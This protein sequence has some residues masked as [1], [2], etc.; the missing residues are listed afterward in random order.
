MKVEICKLDSNRNLA[1][2]ELKW[3]VQ[4]IDS[5]SKNVNKEEAELHAH[6]KSNAFSYYAL[7]A[8]GDK[9]NTFFTF[10]KE[11][12]YTENQQTK[13][14]SNP[15]ALACL[16][17]KDGLL[18][19]QDGKF[20][21]SEIAKEYLLNER[22]S[23]KEFAFI[24]LSKQWIRVDGSCKISLLV[25]LYDLIKEDVDFLDKLYKKEDEVR[26]II[27]EK[28]TGK[29]LEPT[30]KIDF[31]RFDILRNMMETA[32][33]ISHE[34]DKPI[35]HADAQEILEAFHKDSDKLSKY[36]DTDNSFY[37]YI[38]ANNY[39]VLE[40]ISS[41]NAETFAKLYPNL[42]KVVTG[43]NYAC[44]NKLQVIY[45]GSPGTG[46]SYS[47]KDNLRNVGIIEDPNE[48]L[49]E[50]R[51]GCDR[52]FRTTFHP[53]CDYASFVGCYKPTCTVLKAIADTGA[54]E[55][56]VIEAFYKTR[57]RA[58]KLKASYFAEA[59]YHAADIERL[60]LK[61]KDITDKL[62][63]K[64]F[65]KCT[66]GG[67][68]ATIADALLILSDKLYKSTSNITYQFVPQTFTNAYIKAW[69]EYLKNKTNPQQVFLV[70]EE[71]N[72]G[73]CAQIFGDLFQLLDRKKDGFS[74]YPIKADND[75]KNY[76]IGLKGW[77]DKHEGIEDGCLK[78]PPNFNIIAT[79]NTSDQSLFPMDSAF[80]R[81]WDWKYIPIESKCPKSQFIIDIDGN[82]YWWADFIDKVN[83]LIRELTQS[84]DKQLGNFFIKKNIEIEEFK[85]KVMFYLWNEVCKEYYHSNSFFKAKI[86]IDGKTSDKEFTFNDLFSKDGSKYL[87]GFM[88]YL[89]IKEQNT[90]DESEVPNEAE[91]AEPSA[92][93]TEE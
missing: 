60:G 55:E 27:F 74:E 76:L 66:Y 8:F 63:A 1:D 22:I 56:E 87:I 21:L 5:F 24:L 31:N 42:A 40:I 65:D 15:A 72:R 36:E 77:S 47:V 20:E 58:D 86:T 7:P 90:A 49:G 91:S 64:G 34:K 92:E 67:E 11:W 12:I 9:Y 18:F 33:L 26:K 54:T 75:L 57:L 17:R 41:E 62:E 19:D 38:C 45:F 39:G 10:K 81:R 85:S 61:P 13:G 6:N 46:K 71:I 68:L 53:D 59:I 52:L 25:L 23:T 83:E 70:I 48:E 80:K 51:T 32:G 84:E 69:E 2:R 73:N 3:L 4:A 50:V 82:K 30:D 93:K 16:C 28:A 79:M 44:N 35:L 89:E 14:N 88:N 37:T 78:L 29:D 43:K